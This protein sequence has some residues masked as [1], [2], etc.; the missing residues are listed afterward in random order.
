MKNFIVKCIGS[1]YN[2]ISY[3]SKVQAAD[4]A[5]HLFSKPRN[6]RKLSEEQREFLGTAFQ[7]EYKFGQHTIMTYRWLGD[8]P[9]ILLAHGWESNSYRWKNLIDE[10]RKKGHNVVAL[11]APGHGNSGSR[12][13]NAILYSEFIN[14]VAT[15]FQ[16][17][18]IIGH[19]VGGM[20]TVFFQNKYQ[21]N[22]V[23]KLILLGVPSEF[24][25]VLKR[26]TDMLGYNQRI[27]EQLN[28]TI[29]E[30]FGDKLENFSTAKYL[31]GI[32]SKGLIIHD[33]QDAIIPYS[34]ALLIKSSFK[35]STLITTKGLGHSLN[36]E[37]VSNH[38]YE[39][40]L[41]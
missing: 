25:D 2:L 18:I 27:T 33:E 11:D 6:G 32:D 28:L 15:K 10:L 22:S 34:D 37:S 8:K 40:I 13:F 12:L 5:L 20:S 14:V 41:N 35:N 9:T 7:K 4:K 1:Y 31:E 21:L 26:Y 17:E 39:F 38:I 29:I 23:K 3:L 16:P 24:T 30:R 36:D 19:S